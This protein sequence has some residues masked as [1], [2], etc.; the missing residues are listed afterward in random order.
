[1][2]SEQIL[3]VGFRKLDFIYSL[4]TN[5]QTNNVFVLLIKFQPN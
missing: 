2:H 3:Y 4:W 5:N 1:M